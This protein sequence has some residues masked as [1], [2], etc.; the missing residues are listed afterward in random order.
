MAGNRYWNKLRRFGNIS[1]TTFFFSAEMVDSGG[2][3]LFDTGRHLLYT[4]CNLLVCQSKCS[5]SF[6]KEVLEFLS[7]H[8]L[9]DQKVQHNSFF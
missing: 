3:Y 7:F 8:S 5:P 1:T 9:T 4:R 6:L 2:A